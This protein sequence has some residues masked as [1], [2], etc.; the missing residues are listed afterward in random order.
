[1]S[2]S[3]IVKEAHFA[4]VGGDGDTAVDDA[5]RRSERRDGQ[6]DL[7]ALRDVSRHR[8]R[9]EEPTG[10]APQRSHSGEGGLV[11]TPATL[12]QFIAQP[13]HFES[14]TGMIFPGLKNPADVAD[15]VAYIVSLQTPEQIAVQTGASLAETYCGSCHATDL[16][17]L[18]PHPQAPPF[19]E[20]HLRYDVT[21]LMEALVEGLSTG[22]PD[23]PEFEFDPEQASAIIAYL[24]SLS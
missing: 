15:V 2:K 11:W 21:D 17:S 8:T 14:G 18:S 13:K 24:Q 19:R 16:R 9:S 12:A 23:M 20:L 7:R 6:R 3:S 22:H 1:L 4:L 10:T 5:G